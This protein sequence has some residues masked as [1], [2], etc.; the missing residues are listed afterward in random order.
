MRM[1]KVAYLDVPGGKEPDEKVLSV[2]AE[3]Q[4]RRAGVIEQGCDAQAKEH[5]TIPG[6]EEVVLQH[7]VPA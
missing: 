6:T 5:V 2:Y 1:C 4:A 3:V 7:S